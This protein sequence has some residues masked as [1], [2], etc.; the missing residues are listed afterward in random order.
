MMRPFRLLDLARDFRHAFR[1]LRRN[2]A[3]TLVATLTLGLGLGATTAIF[4]VFDAAVLR[5]LPFPDAGRLV[6]VHI[7]AHE[8]EGPAAGKFP[9]SYPK[10]E[11][12]RQT[13][14]S[15]E[16]IAGYDGPT[17]LNLIGRDGP[18]RLG[19]EL[20]SASYFQ[21]LGLQPTAGRLFQPGED[22]SPGEPAVVVLGYGLWQR[23]FGGNRGLIGK[24][25]RLHGRMLTVVGVAPKGFRGLT[26]GADLFVPITLA[27][28]FDYT[29]ILKEAGNHWFS[30]IGRL[31]PGV[32]VASA[33]A[34][35]R[36]AGA[37][38]DRQFHFPEQK[39]AWSATVQELG[40]SRADPGFRRA[41]LQLTGAVG[42]VLLISCVNLTSLLLVRAVGR[43]REVAV[44]VALG[45]ARGRVVRQL[46]AE[47]AAIALIGWGLGVGVG[48]L[49]LPLLLTLGP[50]G[51]GNGSVGL[52][53]PGAVTVDARIAL[54]G[55]VLA[56]AAAVAVGLLP[57]FQATRRDVADSLKAGA[58]TPQ[59]LLSLR[60]PG[61]Q[62][63]LVVSEVALALTLLVGAGLLLR[64]FAGLESL[65]V[66]FDPSH[67]LTLK[68]AA[69]DSDLAKRDSRVFRM[70]VVE[71]LS[72][73]PG[74]E[75]A[76]TALCPPLSERCSGSV[77]VRVDEQHLKMGNGAV[78]IGLHMV[79]AGH[80]RTLG[81]PIL[82]GRGFTPEDRQGS[83]RVVVINE[84]AA[85]KL[86]HGQDALG[87]QLGAASFYFHGGD[88]L[89]TVVGIVPD[90]RYGTYESEA[91]PDLYYP[92]VQV[93]FGG[94]GMIFV[95]TKSDPLALT[96]T[97]RRA[98]HEIDPNIP[99]FNI[100]T[101]EQRAGAALARPRFA[102]TLLG[103]FAGI[104]LLL[105]A[106]GLY[107]VM[108][109]S[110][111]Q[112][113]REIG[114]RMALGAE[115]Q[116]VLR[117]VLRQG[118][119]LAGVGIGL[120]LAGA[121]ALQK[122]MKGMLYGVSG[123]DPLTLVAVSLLMAVAAAGAV[124]VPARRATRVNPMEAL[125]SD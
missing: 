83:P 81:I 23:S 29:E 95:R 7:L 71:R 97:A 100:M 119:V 39:G 115:Q 56:L 1:S 78:P 52:V 48:K 59:G 22:V 73:L 121:L 20:V 53:D 14:R 75:A 122:L 82:R 123:S 34:D 3:F 35:A 41:V 8:S 21:V 60:R 47:S 19:A 76:S 74:V 113:T 102:T 33:D 94:T 105:A 79:T 27:T 61:A 57:A 11:L 17:N 67:V 63:L 118:L 69:A 117:G 68:Y 91:E 38:V 18:E 13:A 4:S 30:V 42:L 90:V 103:T 80:F 125:R 40:A 120:G 15:F 31:K 66:G 46:L 6:T 12:F 45:A 72:A 84:S 70:T 55:L 104:A 65:D 88:S 85:K 43:R 16:G 64:T 62:Q 86:W 28:L 77:V 5:P 50:T 96:E 110:V 9:W 58:A 124:L 51:V 36:M 116:R 108:A 114:L 93:S 111:A 26:G 32:S 49:A 54:A 92:A 98:I 109:F 89:A 44:R 25:I 112:R 24:E 2:P 99:L 10:F 37:V 107:G 106:V 101:M 87:H